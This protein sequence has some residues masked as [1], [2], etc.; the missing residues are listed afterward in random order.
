MPMTRQQK[1]EYSK[2]QTIFKRDE[3]THKVIVNEY[4]LPEFKYLRNNPWVFTEKVDGTNIRVMWDGTNVVFGGKTDNAQMPT[5]LLYKLQELFE[6]IT[7]KQILRETFSA[8][9]TCFT[10]VC[11]YGEGYGAR[12]QKGG[13][14]YIPNGVDFILFDIK[15]GDWWLERVNLEDIGNKLGIKVVPIMGEGTL[16]DM[17]FHCQNGI[18]SSWGDFMAEGLVAKPQVELWDRRGKRIIAKLKHKD[19]N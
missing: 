15:I 8:N 10:D 11:L 16:T 7:K 13:E 17:V 14:K 9:G 6:G 19:F 12:I 18:K 1:K 3:K 2:I 4:S 5:F